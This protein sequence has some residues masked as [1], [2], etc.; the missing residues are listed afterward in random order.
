MSGTN[1]VVVLG[2]A[3]EGVA[4]PLCECGCGGIPL[5][6]GSR[7]LSGHHMKVRTYRSVVKESI[8][9]NCRQTFEHG[10]RPRVYCGRICLYAARRKPISPKTPLEKFLFG[11]WRNSRQSILAFCLERG[12]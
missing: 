12:A 10:G 8:C 11:Q 4:H 6:P 1:A 7:F 3:E 9:V 5:T 2:S